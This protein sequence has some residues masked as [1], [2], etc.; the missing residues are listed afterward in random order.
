MSRYFDFVN[1]WIEGFQK[2]GERFPAL[3]MLAMQMLALAQ[4][5]L[6]TANSKIPV[7]TGGPLKFA[8][9]KKSLLTMVRK[10]EPVEVGPEE[11]EAEKKL[12]QMLSK[13][14]AKHLRGPMD[15][16]LKALGDGAFLRS[17]FAFFQANPQLLSLI[18]QL[19][20]LKMPGG[21]QV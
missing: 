2:Y 11:K 3:W 13:Y 18:L 4:K 17:F 10:M 1:M 6:D 8:A 20:G 21:V 12:K 16:S 5:F 9:A 14:T 19:F 7:E 15:E